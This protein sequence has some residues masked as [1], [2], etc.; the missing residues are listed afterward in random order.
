MAKIRAAPP[1]VRDGPFRRHR[2]KCL[3]DIFQMA[4]PSLAHIKQTRTVSGLAG[5]FVTGEWAGSEGIGH[6]LVTNYGV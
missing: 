5:L 6:E 4:V 3:P 2:E 1:F